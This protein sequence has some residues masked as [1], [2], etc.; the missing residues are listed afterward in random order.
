LYHLQCFKIMAKIQNSQL[1]NDIAYL[2]LL[3][4]ITL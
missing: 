2:F 1:S 3:V 4:T